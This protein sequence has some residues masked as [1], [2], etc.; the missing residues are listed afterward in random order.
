[1]SQLTS[2]EYVS[3]GSASI[4]HD[5][6]DVIQQGS[7][8]VISGSA[9]S[10][11]YAASQSSTFSYGAS[12]SGS[13]SYGASSQASGSAGGNNIATDLLTLMNQSSGSVVSTSTTSGFFSEI[14]Q[15]ILRASNPLEITETEELTVL[16]QRGIWMNRME[17]NGWRGD[18]SIEQY[19]IYEDSNPQ[20]INKKV[21]I[22]VEYV[23]ELAIRYLRPPTPPTPGEIVITMEANYATGPA[24]PLII[25]QAAARAAT[26]EPLIIREAPPQP[27]RPVGPKRITI[28][29]KRNPPPPRKVVIERL[30]ALPSKPQNIII[31]RWLPYNETKR[32]VVFNKAVEVRAEVANPRNVIVQWEAPS[33]NIR[34]EVRYL[35]VVSANPAEY[36]QKYGDSLQMHTSFP[37][38]V[39]DI[40]TPSEVGV[41]AADYTYR[42]VLELEGQLEGFTYVNLDTEGLSEYREQLMAKGFRDL[43]ATGGQRISVASTV[44]S[45]GATSISGG[46]SGSI[47][48]SGSA[49]SASDSISAAASQIF[50]MIDKD[51]S[52]EVSLDEAESIVLKLN[53]RL[54]RAYGET[55]VREFFSAVSGGSNN[56]SRAQF[57]SAFERMTA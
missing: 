12:Q 29:G 14:E 16:G 15:A 45:S 11:A 36:V 28:T 27:P 17:V 7:G 30:A 21:Q 9:G 47:Y 31:E 38:F 57:L 19:Q 3:T 25:R 53:S 43:G 32:R 46:Y 23:Q 4:A 34:K 13:V 2:E 54:K 55:E 8:S 39:L 6:L 5:L 56:I 18:L 44:I 40:K 24:P 51:N 26:P 50:S 20:V 48:A 49:G 42:S 10:A 52:G 1:M 33:V 22:Q 35:G 37:E 41:L